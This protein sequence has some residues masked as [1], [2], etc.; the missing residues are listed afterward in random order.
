MFDSKEA[1][2]TSLLGSNEDYSIE[3]SLFTTTGADELGRRWRRSSA[4]GV[5]S[6]R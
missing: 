6:S 1:C 3:M 5:S 2:L 4:A